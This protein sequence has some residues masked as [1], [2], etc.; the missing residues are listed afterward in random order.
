MK[1]EKKL[2]AYLRIW[3]NIHTDRV[4][5]DQYDTSHILEEDI[6]KMAEDGGMERSDPEAI[7]HLSLCPFCMEKW[8]A[9]REAISVVEEDESTDES[10]MSYGVLRAAATH[11]MSE[12]VSTHSSCGRFVLSISPPFDFDD[13]WLVTLETLKEDVS[14]EGKPIEVRDRN[15]VI[16]L[17]GTINQGRIA[18]FR[19]D[20]SEIDLN[21]WSV[22]E[23]NE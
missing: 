9:W 3:E 15:N 14:I 7:K 18:G 8:A 2:L 21:I 17:S 4:K 11:D 5:A 19:D 13:K 22:T 1:E 16:I 12:A 20:I 6:Y 10:I 23:K